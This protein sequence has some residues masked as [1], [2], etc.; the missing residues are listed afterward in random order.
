MI[1]V[2]V[3]AIYGLK[4]DGLL[5]NKHLEIN[6]R[7]SVSLK[8]RLIKPYKCMNTYVKC[9]GFKYYEYISDHIDGGISISDDCYKIITRLEEV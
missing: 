2:L 7:E 4:S 8:A 1:T 5:F 6:M 3:K 9:S